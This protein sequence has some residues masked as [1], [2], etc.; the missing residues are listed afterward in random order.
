V[1]GAWRRQEQM[2][3]KSCG[4]ASLRF[5]LQLELDF[6]W[7]VCL[8][9][10]LGTIVARLKSSVVRF[11]RVVLKYCYMFISSLFACLRETQRLF[12][13]PSIREAQ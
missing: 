5:F 12:T 10:T 4:L 2:V 9:L 6:I 7:F 3:L 8:L 1:E 13:Y 11:Q